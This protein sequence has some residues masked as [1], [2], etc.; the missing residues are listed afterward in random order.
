MSG[1]IKSTSSN[2]TRSSISQESQRHTPQAAVGSAAPAPQLS[3]PAL[4]G[5][6]APKHSAPAPRLGRVDIRSSDHELRAKAFEAHRQEISKQAGPSN[7]PHLNA[8]DKL[9]QRHFKPAPGGVEIPFTPNS[10]LG[11]GKRVNTIGSSSRDVRVVAAAEVAQQLTERIQDT[12]LLIQNLTADLQAEVDDPGQREL[13]AQALVEARR[14][15]DT[16]ARQYAVFQNESRSIN[17]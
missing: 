9:Q 13:T 5:R 14:D 3:H 6:P 7:N 10:L 1:T 4:Q 8:L 17:R 15:L 12:R 16:Y 11:G 2:L